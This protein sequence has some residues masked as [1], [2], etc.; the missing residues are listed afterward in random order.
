VDDRF[1]QKRFSYACFLCGFGK[2]HPP[3][4]NSGQ[5]AAQ[6]LSS[7]GPSIFAGTDEI[8]HNIIAKG[9]LGL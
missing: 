7:P 9:T 4:G 8:Q 1:H 2:N 6:C 5:I 3:S